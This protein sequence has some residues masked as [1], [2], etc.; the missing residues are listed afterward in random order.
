[1]TVLSGTT[2]DA[3][4][5]LNIY[6][7]VTEEF[8]RENPDFLGAK[9]IMSGLRF[10]ESSTIKESVKVAKTLRQKYPHFFAGYD[11]VG[12]EDPNNPL[13]FYSSTLRQASKELPYYFHAAET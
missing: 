2:H 13:T 4:F 11:L 1:F 7:Q 12:Q 6:K 3:E 8:V 5:G 10:F 9:I